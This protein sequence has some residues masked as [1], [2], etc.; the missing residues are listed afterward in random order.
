[1]APAQNADSIE[2]KPEKSDST[3]SLQKDSYAK[4]HPSPAAAK[5]IKEG[6]IDPSTISGSGKDGRITKEDVVKSKVEAPKPA[7]EEAK[8]Y[9]ASEHQ[10]DLTR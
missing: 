6:N 10:Q 2:V 7:V 4:G 3:G 5:L 1:M 9:H 8:D